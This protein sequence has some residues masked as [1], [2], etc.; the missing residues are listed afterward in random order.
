MTEYHVS[1][2]K[3][4]IFRTAIMALFQSLT[5]GLK[6]FTSDVAKQIP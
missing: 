4:T 1:R 3:V 6:T 5:E 2:T